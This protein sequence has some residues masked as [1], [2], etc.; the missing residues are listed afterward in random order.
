MSKKDVNL[1]T[2]FDSNYLDKGIVLYQS[3]KAVCD[4]FIL[5]VF[6]FDEKAKEILELL[7]YDNMVVI[8]L[9][10]FETE[11]LREVKNK[12]SRG[13]YCWTCTPI[14][15]QHV[16]DK[17]NVADCTYIDS[18]LFFYQSPEVLLKE[19][20][21]SNCSVGLVKHRFPKTKRGRYNE[22]SSG[23][24]CVQF[25]TFK[26]DENARKLLEIWKQ[27]CL[28][29]CSIKKG[30]DQYYITDWGRLYDQVYEYQNIG[31]GVA[32]WN[33]MNYKLKKSKFKVDLTYLNENHEL[34]FYH[35][36]GIQYS[37][38]GQVNINVITASGGGFIK[39]KYINYLYYPYLKEIEIVR[40]MLM[41]DYQ[42]QYFNDGCNRNFKSVKFNLFRFLHSFVRR[43]F[44]ESLY[45]AI[46]FLFRV[47][48]KK[49]D[50]IEIRDVR[51]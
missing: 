3:L 20:Y 22:K 35:F 17:Y 24:Y 28:F 7:S 31:A 37:Q 1:C 11:E 45:S 42:I 49:Y 23:T 29:E 5:F 25:N 8:G 30:G 33:L 48:R 41:Q 16:L 43:I 34:V 26:N 2:V 6:A 21:A 27:Q 51:K 39:K 14:V 36:Q 40:D 46:E 12:R 47:I 10:D 19:F 13:E 9:K 32:P 44:K 38:E 18:D 50:I 4:N 15:I